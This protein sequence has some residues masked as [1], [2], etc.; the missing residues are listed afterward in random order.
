MRKWVIEIEDEGSRIDSWAASKTELSRTKIAQMIKEGK[1]HLNGQPTKANARLEVDDEVAIEKYVPTPIDLEPV[2]MDLDIIF[3]DD[4]VLVVNKPKGIVVH[5][6]AGTKE[7]TLVHGLLYHTS[8]L[9]LSEDP[10]RPGIVHRLDK[11]TSGLLVVAKNDQAHEF[12]ANQLADRSMNRTYQAIVHG[13]FPYLKAKVDA[14]LG[15][16]SKNRQKMTVTENNSKSAITHLA[17]KE[18]FEDYSLLECKLETGRTHQIRA[19]LEY[20]NY[21]IV[22]DTLYSFKNTPD[23]GGQL[24]HAYQLQFIHPTRKELMSFTCEPPQV[25][26]D[27]LSEVRRK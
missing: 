15:R 4:A 27:F 10:V 13:V 25:F 26:N 1:V 24:L 21:P 14:P 17:L 7:P 19:H 20:I 2:K 6:G 16:D 23:Y 12:L 3:E 11:D 8:T 5:P 9:S 22:G 18:T